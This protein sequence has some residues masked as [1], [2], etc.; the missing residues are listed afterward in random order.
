MVTILMNDF[1]NRQNPMFSVWI[2]L[3]FENFCVTINEKE[4]LWF[5]KL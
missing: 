4:K 1:A 2:S 5:N 3:S